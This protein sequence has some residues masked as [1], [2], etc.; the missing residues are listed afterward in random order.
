[1]Q[2]AKTAM[3]S[4]VSSVKKNFSGVRTGRANTALIDRINVEYYGSAVPLNQ[5][6]AVSI[7]EPRQLMITP[8]DKTATSAIEKAILTSDLGI[9]PQ[10]GSDNI[11]I[12][13]PMLTE[14]RR[15]EL[16]KIVK[17]FSEE[18]KVSVRNARHSA[19]D[20][21]KKQEKDKVISEDESRKM[22]DEV[23]LITDKYTTEIDALLKIKED[24]VMDN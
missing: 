17:Q 5:L 2:D 23:Q 4:A 16:V 9:T 7:P 21:I 20:T 11:R 24:E 19:I 18:G 12:V 13:L 3:E 8:F 15:K 22:Q 14:D 10:T 6:A 1:M